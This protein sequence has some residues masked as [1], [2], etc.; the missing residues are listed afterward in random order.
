MV[1]YE[2]GGSSG[3]NNRQP[4]RKKGRQSMRNSG[5]GGKYEERRRQSGSGKDIREIAARF[6]QEVPTTGV[7]K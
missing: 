4:D 1:G 3:R 2:E 6:V 5:I 7:S